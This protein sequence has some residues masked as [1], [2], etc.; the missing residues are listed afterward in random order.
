[1][2]FPTKVIDTNGELATDGVT[3]KWRFDLA[4]LLG[5]PLRTSWATFEAS[6]ELVL[7]SCRVDPDPVRLLERLLEAP[8]APRRVEDP[9]DKAPAK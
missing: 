3:V 2:V 6:D 1:M 7:E 4:D 5:K 8:P 9:G